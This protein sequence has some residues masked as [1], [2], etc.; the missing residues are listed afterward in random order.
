MFMLMQ[1]WAYC[2]RRG[3]KVG[4]G[5]GMQNKPP[6][7]KIGQIP[8]A[9]SQREPRTKSFAE[10]DLYIFF[11]EGNNREFGE[12]QGAH[13][14]GQQGVGGTACSERCPAE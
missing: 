10:N 7:K 5:G 6:G 2:C 11:T 8:G 4:W 9:G 1:E 13:W 3:V 14:Q 12:A